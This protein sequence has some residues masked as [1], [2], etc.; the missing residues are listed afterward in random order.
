MLT[1]LDLAVLNRTEPFDPVV[2]QIIQSPPKPLTL[3]VA[4]IA[5][6]KQSVLELP[7]ELRVAV[8]LQPLDQV[9]KHC[10]ERYSKPVG[11]QVIGQRRRAVNLARLRRER[12]LLQSNGGQSPRPP[13]RSV[14][15]FR[16]L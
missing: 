3:L 8:L 4:E 15:F 16:V 13:K 6:V 2:E 14:I 7:S 10:L 1:E 9:S 11:A 12:I 5:D